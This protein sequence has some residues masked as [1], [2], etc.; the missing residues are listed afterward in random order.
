MKYHV[1][2]SGKAMVV[3]SKEVLSSSLEKA[4]GYEEN[5]IYRSL[6]VTKRHWCQDETN[7]Q[8]GAQVVEQAL[9]DAQITFADLDLLIYASATYDYPLPTTAC[10]IQREL[11][12][13]ASGVP[14]IHI[15]SSCLS[16]LTALEMAAAYIQLGSHKRICIVSA[17]I[18]SKSLNEKDSHT[19]FLFG[20]GA[21]ALVLEASEGRGYLEHFYFKTWSEGAFYSYV[22]GGGNVN[23]GGKRLDPNLFTFHMSGRKIILFSIK[24][25]R[26]FLDEY[27]G[28]PNDS[29]ND[30]DLIV[31][32]QASKQGLLSFSNLYKISE[33]KVHT[34][35]GEYGNCVAASIPM[36]LVDAIECGKIQRG[37]RILLI[38]TAAGISVGAVSM[39]Y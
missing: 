29:L 23:R 20:D 39:V 35:I 30:Y 2:V 7:A 3:P 9:L 8:L 37:D 33:E 24:K 5:F 31:P 4:M 11:G 27:I 34:I 18:P 1:R 21:A 36:A 17:E 32:H 19:Y 38:G 14:C 25:I 26:E 22:P 13:Q 12:Q 28:E 10:F 15:N 16:F 6:G